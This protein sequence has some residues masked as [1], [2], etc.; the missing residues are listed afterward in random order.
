MGIDTSIYQNQKLQEAPSILDSQQKAS[1]LR[2]IGLQ[3]Q[4]MGQQINTAEREEKMTAHLQK[5]SQFGSALESMSGMSPEQRASAYPSIRNQLLKEGI[6]GEQD[7]PPEHDEGFYRQSLSRFQ[8]SREGIDRALE[9]AKT[10]HYY[11]QAR[12]DRS[13]V[14]PNK[15]AYDQLPPEN[16]KQI[17]TIASKTGGKVAIKN[18]IDSALSILDD[19]KVSETQ[20]IVIGQQLLKTL[21]STE[22]SD[23]VGAEEVKR[24]GSLLDNKFLNLKQPG[25]VFGRDLPEFVNQVKLTSGTLGQGTARNRAEIDTLYGRKGRQVKDIDIPATARSDQSSFVTSAYAAP[26]PPKFKQVVDGYQYVG[27]PGGEADKKNWRRSK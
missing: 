22:G 19:A 18:Q 3:Q 12:A 26:P 17:D 2:T 16:Q 23:A 4:H 11:D 9:K 5:A 21:N 27:P 24:L 15:E 6:V 25:S 1:N 20:K 13:K 14:N 8:Q 7:I 10:A